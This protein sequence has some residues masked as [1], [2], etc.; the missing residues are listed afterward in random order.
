MK[1]LVMQRLLATISLILLSGCYTSSW[2]CVDEDVTRVVISWACQLH[3]EQFHGLIL[4]E[5]SSYSDD[6]LRSV[7]V[8]LTTTDLI[9]LCEARKLLVEVA[10]GFI[11]G[12]N[13][14]P[15]IAMRL[16]YPF[17]ANQ[18]N[19][20]ITFESLF[21]Q[22]VDERYM[23]QVRL[24]NGVVTYYAFDAF[25]PKMMG[26]HKHTESF[27]QAVIIKDAYENCQIPKDLAS[28]GDVFGPDLRNDGGPRTPRPPFRSSSPSQRTGDEYGLP[29]PM[30][31]SGS[32]L[33]PRRREPLPPP[34]ERIDLGAPRV[35]FEHS[36]S[37]EPR[38]GSLIYE[39][40]NFV[41]PRPQFEQYDDQQPKDDGL[42]YGPQGW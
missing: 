32:S 7:C 41:D 20:I 26:F 29:L 35:E 13:Y 42:N 25:D 5:S 40:D 15:D 4:E 22:Y 30:P 11:D 19:L 6:Y 12:I 10:E 27:E 2:R 37:A 33:P 17:S 21:G 8:R 18:L 34:R 28:P 23:N 14:H 3:T 1:Q 16:E 36:D 9:D 39:P 38:D 24:Q 31:P